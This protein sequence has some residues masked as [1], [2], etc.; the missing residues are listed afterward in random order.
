MGGSADFPG[1]SMRRVAV[2]G[3]NPPCGSLSSERFVELLSQRLGLDAFSLRPAQKMAFATGAAGQVPV[4]ARSAGNLFNIA[5]TH[6]EADTLIWL[7]F[8]PRAYLRDWLAG[9]LDSLLNGAA[10]ARRRASR[11]RLIDLARS[12]ASI[13]QPGEVNRRLTKALQPQLLLVELCSPE[14]AF[15]WIQMQEERAR[16]VEPSAPQ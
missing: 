5:R 11:A 8:S 10:G 14:Q 2:I 4:A 15:F 16:E 12:C 3:P 7:H 13:L 1:V 9:W 6:V